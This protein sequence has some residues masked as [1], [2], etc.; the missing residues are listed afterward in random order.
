METDRLKMVALS[1]DHKNGFSALLKDPEVMRWVCDL[2]SFEQ[3]SE[4]FNEQVGRIGNFGSGWNS[5]AVFEKRSGAFVGVS[6]YS[7]PAGEVAFLFARE[8]HGKGFGAE[9][10]G[11]LQRIAKACGVKRLKAHVTEGNFASCRVLE[12]CS[13]V[14]VATIEGSV[15]IGNCTYNDLIFEY[16]F[17]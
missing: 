16:E 11:M 3:I 7:M 4:R 9:S 14:Q 6:G 1:E 17:E 5:F 10:L 8:S 2:P 13:F 15:V 12:R